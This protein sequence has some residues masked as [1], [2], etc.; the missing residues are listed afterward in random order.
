MHQQSQ[1]PLDLAQ[2]VQVLELDQQQLDLEGQE[3]LEEVQ[4]DLDSNPEQEDLE[5][6]LPLEQLQPVV[7]LE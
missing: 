3:G 7:D 6:G 1:V 4:Q 5:Q 2:T